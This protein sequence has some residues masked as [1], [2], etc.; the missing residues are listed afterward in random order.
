MKKKNPSNL[1]DAVCEA[2]TSFRSINI[3]FPPIYSNSLI[4]TM[5]PFYSL[6]IFYFHSFVHVHGREK[7]TQGRMWVVDCL[8]PFSVWKRG[9]SESNWWIAAITESCVLQLNFNSYVHQSFPS[10]PFYNI[11]DTHSFDY[12]AFCPC[13]VLVHQKEGQKRK[14]GRDF[15]F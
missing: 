7:N 3:L 8:L 12:R 15:S 14:K 2:S 4:H 1:P 11:M 13:G 10:P 5:S 9:V 6:F